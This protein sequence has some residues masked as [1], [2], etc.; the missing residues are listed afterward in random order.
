MIYNVNLLVISTD[1]LLGYKNKYYLQV[2]LDSC[3]YTIVDKQIIDYL[4]D[5]PFETGVNIKSYKCCIM[6]ELI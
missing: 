4:G 2:Y 1:S 3:A 5:S 6:I